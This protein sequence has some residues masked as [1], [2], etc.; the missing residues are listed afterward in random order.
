MNLCRR[1]KKFLIDSLQAVNPVE[2]LLTFQEGTDMTK[3]ELQS[4]ASDLVGQAYEQGLSDA[5]SAGSEPTFTQAQVDAV[6]AQAKADEQGRI[7]SALAPVFQ[8]EE[9]DILAVVKPAPAEQS[10]SA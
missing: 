2:N 5:Q 7:A 10:P 6:V 9:A 4:Q 3:Q 8:K 1:L